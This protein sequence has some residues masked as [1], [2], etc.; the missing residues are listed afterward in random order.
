MGIGEAIQKM[1]TTENQLT[2]VFEAA[3]VMN[4]PENDCALKFVWFS[5]QAGYTSLAFPKK[6]PL[7]PF[8]MHFYTIMLETGDFDKITKSWGRGMPNCKSKD[9][10]FEGISISKVILVIFILIGG[11]LIASGI[12]VCEMYF[13]KHSKKTQIDKPLENGQ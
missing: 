5:P 2:L 7:Y 3:A 11:V 8:F 13:F 12:L 1:K 4:H 10:D 9:I 6:S